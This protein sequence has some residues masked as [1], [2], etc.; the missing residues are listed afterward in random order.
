MATE[1]IVIP[2]QR[3][4]RLLRLLDLLDRPVKEI[5]L[6]PEAGMATVWATDDKG[7]LLTDDNGDL[8]EQT[9]EIEFVHGAID[10][11]QASS[12]YNQDL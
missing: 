3:Q 6:T 2:A 9:I 8:I 4:G 10:P 11:Q 7:N 5:M 1:R 12:R